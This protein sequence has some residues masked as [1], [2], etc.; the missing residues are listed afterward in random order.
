M[1]TKTY[2]HCKASARRKEVTVPVG[3]KISDIHQIYKEG[4]SQDGP[5]EHQS[6][7]FVVLNASIGKITRAHVSITCQ[8]SSGIISMFQ[9]YAEN[10]KSYRTDQVGA[11]R[12]L[13]AARMSHGCCASNLGSLPPSLSLCLSLCLSSSLSLFF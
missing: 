13:R 5:N 10:M 11:S 6:I 2:L 12:V 7:F 4:T 8:E 1:Y 3:S 9:L